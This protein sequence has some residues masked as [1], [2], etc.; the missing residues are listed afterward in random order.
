MRSGR[1]LLRRDPVLRAIVE[2][3]RRYGAER[4]ILFGSRA[5]GDAG[6][7]SDYDVVVV[8]RTR[9]RF[10][11]RLLEV[12][13][14]LAPIRTPVDVFIYTPKEFRA[15]LQRTLG[16]ILRREGIVLYEA[17]GRRR[18]VAPSGRKRP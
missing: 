15:M 16:V 17:P 2:A 1:V 12:D 4:I 6:P 7:W 5:R 14:F 9:R 10:L 13:P 3:L 8:R 11:D 18:S